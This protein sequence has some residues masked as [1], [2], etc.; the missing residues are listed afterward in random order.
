MA[1]CYCTSRLAVQPSQQQAPLK[2]AQQRNRM[3]HGKM[4]LGCSRPWVLQ[5]PWGH[6]PTGPS[7]TA[8]VQ[9][10][11]L[12]RPANLAIVCSAHPNQGISQNLINP[13]GPVK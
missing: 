4:L 10:Q 2:Q 12:Q 6:R 7:H 11:K 13:R 8:K 1:V 3:H 9:G 5:P